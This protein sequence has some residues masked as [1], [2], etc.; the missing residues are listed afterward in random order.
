MTEIQCNA[1]K[2]RCA[3]IYSKQEVVVFDPLAHEQHDDIVGIDETEQ[4]SL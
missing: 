4:V 3:T 1:T 2:E